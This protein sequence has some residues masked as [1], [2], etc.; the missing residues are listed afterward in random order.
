MTKR[1]SKGGQ[2][3]GF[4]ITPGEIE[5]KIIALDKSV[6]ALNRS[7]EANKTK[8]LNSKWRAEW[9]AYVRRWAIER[10]S[11]ATYESRLFATRV[12]PRLE[13]FEENY[14]WWARD[15]QKLAGVAPAVP[16]ARPSEGLIDVV[17]TGGWVL[18]AV[19]VMAYLYLKSDA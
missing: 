19:A 2:V 16:T 8:A 11:Y 12:M 1:K 7:I 10:D 3:V 14:R 17:P 13:K 18:A 4:I 9:D 5:N 15:F 6:Q